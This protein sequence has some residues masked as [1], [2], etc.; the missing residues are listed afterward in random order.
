MSDYFKLY[1]TILSTIQE[2]SPKDGQQLFDALSNN[3]YI[4]QEKSSNQSLVR[5]TLNA[6]DNLIADGM[7]NAKRTPTKSAPIY[8][9]YGLSTAGQKLLNETKKPSF[10]EVLKGYLKENGLP[11]SPQSISRFV[12]QVIF[13]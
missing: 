2:A 7:V 12:A 5:E 11:V 13:R 1:K 6:L 4:I 10:D 3:D 8:E 9:I